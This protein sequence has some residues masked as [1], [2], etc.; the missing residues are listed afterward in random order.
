VVTER[1]ETREDVDQE[2]LVQREDNRI[3]RI[4]FRQFLT[5]PMFLQVCE[6]GKVL[7]KEADE[8]DSTFY[9]YF[10]VVVDCPGT[11]HCFK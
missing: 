2:Q 5:R 1:L 3:S 8:K 11:I 9:R 7:N 10:T 4:H 6:D